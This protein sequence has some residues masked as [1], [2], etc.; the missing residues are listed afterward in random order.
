MGFLDAVTPTHAVVHAAAGTGKT[1]LLTSRIVRMLLDG[2]EPGSILAITF[3]RK[4]AAE[5]HQRLHE[6]LFTLASADDGSLDKLLRELRVEP[7]PAHRA[8]ARGLYESMLSA[9]Y[10]LRTT[11][12]HAFCQ[13]LLQRFPL[14]AEVPPHFELCEYTAEV[15]SAAWLALDRELTR[16]PRGATAQAMDLLLRRAG[17]VAA[18]RSALA[19]FL[20]HRSDWWFYAGFASDPAAY[21]AAQLPAALNISPDANP[22]ATLLM[23]ATFRADL[24]AYARLLRAHPNATHAAWLASIESALAPHPPAD[25]F[26]RL[27]AVFLTAQGQPRSPK[28]TK[29]LTEK[30]GAEGVGRLQALHAGIVQRLCAVD[31]ERRRMATYEISAAWYVCGQ[32]LL[33]HFQRLKREQNLL[34]FTDLEWHTYRLLTTGQHAEWVQYKLDRRIAHLLVDE[35]QDTNPTQWRLLLPLLSEMAAGDTE[36]TRSIFIVGDEKQS[37]YRF[38]RAEPRLFDTA[39]RWLTQHARASTYSQH[40]SRRSAPAVIRFINLIFD[41][42]KTEAAAESDKPAAD[43]ALSGFQT[44]ETIHD[45]LWGIAELLPLIPRQPR[46]NAATTAFRNPLAQPRIVEEDVRHRREGDMIAD[47][48]K[49]LIGHAIGIGSA[50]RPL[51]YGDIMVLLRDRTRAAAYEEALQHAGIPYVGAERGGFMQ[52]LEVRDL[53]QLLSVLTTPDDDVAVASVLRAPIFSAS[54]AHIIGLAG[55]DP[56]ASW[57][58]RLLRM[59]PHAADSP[60]ARAQRLLP[61]WSELAD[62][63]PVHDLLDRIYCD[64][65]IVARYESAAPRHLK[66]RVVANLHRL[67]ALALEVDAGRFPSLARFLSRLEVIT[68]ED[69]DAAGSRAH[70]SGGAVRIMTVHA[71]KGLEAPAVFLANAAQPLGERERGMRALVEWPVEDPRPRYFHLIGKKPALDSVSRAALERQSVAARREEANLLY[72]ALSRAKQVLYV[73]GCEPARDSTDTEGGYRRARGWYGFIEARLEQ[74]ARRDDAEHSGLR[75]ARIA[76][77]SEPEIHNTYGGIEYGTRPPMVPKTMSAAIAPA[78]VDHALTRPFD[79]PAGA[80][81]VVF[82]SRTVDVI[83]DDGPHADIA[84]ELMSQAK[85]RGLAIH[86]ALELLTANDQRNDRTAIKARLA[87]EWGTRAA[88]GWIDE[89]WRESCAVVDHAAF[90]SYFDPSQYRTARN[91]VAV[92]YRDDD[93]EVYGIIDRLVVR[94]DEIV[95]IDYKTH[96][97]NPAERRLLTERFGAQLRLYAGGIRRLW[98]GKPVR[99]MLLFTAS[100]ETAEID[101]KEA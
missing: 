52:C 74:A 90:G 35:F 46:L 48:I 47:R 88:E 56:A 4:A 59:T 2:V 100:R 101:L 92:L 62:R 99:A 37:I 73:S 82:P 91:E 45:S 58:Q 70:T 98:P 97:A 55:A 17:D 3:T 93:R 67:L 10:P 6:R 19:A 86:R 27:L 71:A 12:F 41:R 77:P 76:D 21:A 5:M 53:V 20:R 33:D 61:A 51:E 8:T 89:C 9:L 64:G 54:D 75:V 65:D 30:L 39:R 57:Y 31:D 11:T 24:A 14:E 26:T 66:N 32:R 94:E 25:A 72:V 49:Q 1:W 79:T 85:R 96:R 38:R 69:N 83:E 78:T 7:D 50:T 81:G 13:E 36:R 68:S 28:P 16:D 43:F 18:V 44:H 84:I 60:I 95:L 63:V 15:E 40:V 23:D 87:Q 29:V 80:R 22:A 34:D 42:P